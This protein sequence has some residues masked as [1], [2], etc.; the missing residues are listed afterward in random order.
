MVPNR[1]FIVLK[2]LRY[3]FGSMC[4]MMDEIEIEHMRMALARARKEAKAE[5][6][7]EEPL[8]A[9]AN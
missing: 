3:V 2:Y 5:P 8:A 4:E 9:I 1:N 6:L 7:E